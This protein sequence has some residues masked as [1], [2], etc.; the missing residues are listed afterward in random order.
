MG[1]STEVGAFIALA[2]GV[3]SFLSPCLLPIVPSF[4]AYL[5]GTSFENLEEGGT[6]ERRG[7]VLNALMFVLGFSLVFV[8]L[9]A[10]AS[11][12][13]RL[14]F[15]YQDWLI[16]AS[17]VLIL[18][19]GLFLMGVFRLPFLGREY[20]P[21]QLKNK[22]AGYLGSLVVG[23]AFGVGWTP[24][25]G[26]VLGAILTLAGTAQGVGRGV[27]LL[28]FYSMGMAIPFLLSALLFRSFLS[29]FQGYKRFIQ[30]VHVGGGA[31]L[32]AVGVLLLSGYFQYLN[33][34]AAYL[35]PSWIV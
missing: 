6:L 10:S 4:L 1:F 25:I 5:S 8:A 35:T 23:F 31:V 13:G 7:L 2:G 33:I 32:A 28:S 20:R 27:L 18:L 29:F 3:F 34:Y 12:I 9:G 15:H 16:E 30:A 17:G 11:F 22:P 21:I 26:P 24:C 14:L 19:L